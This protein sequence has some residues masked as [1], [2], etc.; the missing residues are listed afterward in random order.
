MDINQIIKI[1]YQ[2]KWLIFWVTVLGTVLLFDLMV[3]QPVQYKVSSKVLV[4]QK[5]IA[6]QDIYSISK[7]SQYLS[8]I[9]RQAIYSDTF[10]NEVIKSP[11]QIQATDFSAETKQ[12]RKQWQK[13]VRVGITRDLGILEIEVFYPEKEKAERISQAVISVLT[14]DHQL[15]H[16]GGQ[17]VVLKVLDYPLVNQ[18]PV[19]INIWLGS[20]MG[21]LIG[22]LIGSFWAIKRPK[23]QKLEMTEPQTNALTAL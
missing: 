18:K 16:G 23:K 5:Q 20:I 13:T 6:G 8:Q 12:R 1:L 21:A 11:H 17:N 10:F 22:F 3:I 4:I 7:S 9:M 2:R 19:T 14:K 15:Y